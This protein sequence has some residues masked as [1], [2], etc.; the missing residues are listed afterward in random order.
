MESAFRCAES[1]MGSV[2]VAWR[3][4]ALP[5][6][7]DELLGF[8]ERLAAANDGLLSDHPPPAEEFCF[9]RS[10]TTAER[11]ERLRLRPNIDR[12]ERNI[13]DHIEVDSSV[14]ADPREFARGAEELG[15][16]LVGSEGPAAE[17][18]PFVL[19]LDAPR[20]RIA[21]RL[22]K[23]TIHGI[24]FKVFGVGY[25]WYPGEDRVSFVFL[26]CPEVLFLDGRI[27]D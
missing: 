5:P 27:V 9:A 25:P 6:H 16:P 2:G 1:T 23:A 4:S 24:N 11:L 12:I 10:F 15:L 20:S 14:F 17:E 21:V 22:K 19:H 13:A 18:G 3:G 8:L 26:H 7:Q